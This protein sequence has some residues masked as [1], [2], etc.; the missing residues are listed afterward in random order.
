VWTEPGLGN[1]EAQVSVPGRPAATVQ[2]AVVSPGPYAALA[3]H[4]PWGGFPARLLS[5]AG[6]GGR[7]P[8]LASAGVAAAVGGAGRT[9][10][11]SLDGARVPVRIRGVIG[12]TPAEPSGGSFLVVPQWAQA[13]LDYVPGPN[14]LLATGPG[15]SSKAF[16]AVAARIGR[17]AII[18]QRQ[19]ILAGLRAA[20]AQAAA[21]RVDLLGIW[22]AGALIVLALLVGLAVS[23]AR[24]SVLDAQ[25]SALGMTAGQAR[26]LDLMQ[27][28]PLLAAGIT[29][30]LVAT[31][32]LALLTG[33]ALNLAVFA[34]GSGETGPSSVSVQVQPGPLL[35]TAAGAV[36][37]AAVI[38]A[39]Q[40]VL[41]ARRRLAAPAGQQEAG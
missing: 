15:T 17:G 24:R 18:T 7:V 5:Q 34:A 35:V 31:I 8:V 11:V 36:A 39:A 1:F 16:A 23:A 28:L 22:A 29:G 40:S 6:Q 10:T 20:P 37:A 4:T 38:M 26:A 13:Q 25:M 12:P 30:M 9:A 41:A 19:Q 2:L 3:A 32:G 21:D 14:L 27:A 33:S